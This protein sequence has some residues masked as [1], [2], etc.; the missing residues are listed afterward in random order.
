MTKTSYV[1]E[2]V[3]DL[4][5]GRGKYVDQFA[6]SEYS[7]DFEHDLPHGFGKIDWADLSTFEGKV[8]Q[9]RL[10]EGTFGFA[11]GSVYVGTFS[12]KS[13]KF[14]GPQG[15]YVTEEAITKGEWSEGLLHG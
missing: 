1:G 11:S 7:G 12:L 9:G 8:F 14:D 5:Q 15:E 2:F 10:L 3:D 4:R 13:A 6:T